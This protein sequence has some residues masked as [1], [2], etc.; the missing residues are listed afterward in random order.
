MSRKLVASARRSILLGQGGRTVYKIYDGPWFVARPSVGEIRMELRA[1]LSR[2][3]DRLYSPDYRQQREQY[4]LPMPIP[5]HKSS[6][7]V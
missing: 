7:S 1:L 5:Q 3:P 2:Q 4:G 6:G